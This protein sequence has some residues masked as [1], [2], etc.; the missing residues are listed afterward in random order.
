MRGSHA[1]RRC[2]STRRV[3]RRYARYQQW[4]VKANEFRIGSVQPSTVADAVCPSLATGAN[5]LAASTRIERAATRAAR[6][7]VQAHT[8]AARYIGRGEGNQESAP[9][10]AASHSHFGA[11]LCTG[12]QRHRRAPMGNLTRG[13][14]KGGVPVLPTRR[15]AIG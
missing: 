6:T 12:R 13:T 15:Q 4:R 14:P 9:P 7:L 11:I 2:P 5:A 8:T 1:H 10:E 3:T